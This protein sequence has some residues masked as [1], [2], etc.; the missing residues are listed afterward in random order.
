MRRGEAEA[1]QRVRE[2]IRRILCYRQM[3]IPEHARDD[4]EQEIMT[5][6][7]Q[8]VNRT[9]FD[10][11]AGFW[12]FVEVVTSR[13]CIDW[14]RAE[15]E[16]APGIEI[17]R[18]EGKDP[19]DNVLHE[20]RSKIASRILQSLDTPCRQLITM[21]LHEAMSYQEI[22][23]ALGK[24]EG[25]VRVQMHRCIRNAQRLID[26]H[27]PGLWRDLGRGGSHESS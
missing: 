11:S 5:H 7:W 1:F 24:S 14:L 12:G 6:V 22:S 13:R 4:I 2:R 21:R 17:L 26:K 10:F 19:L 27:Y 20:E 18:D 23:R 25:A 8:A 9:G 15:R 3:R 16:T